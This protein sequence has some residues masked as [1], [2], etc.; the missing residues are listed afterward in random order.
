MTNTALLRRAR[1]AKAW[2]MDACFPL[3]AERGVVAGGFLEVLDLQHHPIEDNEVRVRVQ[4]RQTYVYAEAL[5]LGWKP[6]RAQSL[7]QLG[8]NT[9]QTAC[10][11]EDGLFGRRLDLDTGTLCDDTADLYDTAFALYAMASARAAEPAQ[12]DNMIART[13][14]AIAAQLEDP[15][16]GYKESLP[17]PEYRKQNPHMHLFEASLALISATGDSE[18]F[19]RAKSLNALCEARFIDPK[20]GTLGE[21]FA[22]GDWQTPQGEPG[23]IVEPGHHFE[24]VWLLCEFAR[25]T[26]GADLENAKRLYA[27]ACNTLDADGRAIQSC[28]RAGVPKD[29]SRRTWPQT[30][31][32]KAH[33]AMWKAGDEDAAARAVTSFDILMDEY[34]TPAGGWIDHYDS[35]GQVLAKDMPASTGYHVVLAFIE[36][37]NTVGA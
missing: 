35:D 37:I 17:P 27:F 30:E 16:G 3:W 36:L 19:T 29:T 12:A 18:H 4:A 34:L 5:K 31:A 11:R 14:S 28:T 13:C 1:E 25:K 23:E 26:G 20:T 33:L 8:L 24:W 22:R 2:L 10:W 32:L 9:L 7:I 21:Y 6:L 15:S